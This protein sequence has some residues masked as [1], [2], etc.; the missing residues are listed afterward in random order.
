MAN[1]RIYNGTVTAAGT[2]G[3]AVSEGTGTNPIT[4]SLIVDSTNGAS[5]A[6]KC[7]IRCDSGYTTS[8]STLI[9]TVTESNG[10]YSDYSG[11]NVQLA[12]DNSYADAAAALSGATWA[13]SLTLSGVGATNKIFWVKFNAAAASN[14]ANDDSVKIYYNATV[15]AAS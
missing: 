6:V 10:S 1:I 9:K 3:T 15:S 2:D 11:T 14:P 5:A 12:A 4:A 7:A 8:G 13:N